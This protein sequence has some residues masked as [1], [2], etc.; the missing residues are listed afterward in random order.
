MTR[1]LRAP[2]RRAFRPLCDRLET[3]SL[4][5]SFPGTIVP[6]LPNLPDA[7]YSTVPASGDVNPYGVAYV[8]SNFPKVGATIHAGD[9][10]VSNFNASSNVQGTGTTIVDIH[11]DGTQSLF[12]TS[13]QPGL[14]TALGVLSRGFVVVGNVPSTLAPGSLQ[15]IDRAG[16]LVYTLTDS[17]LLD[18]PWDLT[19]VDHGATAQIFVSNVLSG[20][21]SRVNVAISSGANPITIQSITQLA[22]GYEHRT[23]PTA[24]VIGPTGL[25]Y[26][27]SSGTLYVASTGNNAIYG[28]P[29]AA[30]STGGNTKGTLVYKD[31][32]HL[33]GP[34]GLALAPNG[35]LLTTNGDAVHANPAEPSEL[36]EFTTAGTFVGELSLDPAQGAAFGLAVNQVGKAVTVATVNDDHNTLDL[37]TTTAGAV[38]FGQTNLVSDIPGVASFTDPNLKNPW[39]ISYGPG[40]PFWVSDNNLFNRSAGVSTLYNTIGQP[41]PPPPFGPLVVS[42]PGGLPTGQFF[43]PT[44]DFILPDG[45]K[46][47]FFFATLNGTIAGW[48]FAAGTTA[49][50]VASNSGAVYT[51]LTWANN[52]VANY[53]YAADA[54]GKIDVY[55]SSFH[56]VSGGGAFPFVDPNGTNGL[57]PY[58]IQALGGKLYVTYSGPPGS[59]GGI[60]DVFDTNGNFLRRIASNVAGGPLEEP[61]GLALAPASFGQFG[62]D[63]LVGN[64]LTGRISAFNPLTGNF[65]GEIVDP[66]GNQVSIPGLWGLIF[67]NGGLGGTRGTLYFVAGINGY[68]DGLLGALAPVLSPPPPG[69]P[70]PSSTV[71]IP[72]GSSQNGLPTS[73]L[74][75]IVPSNTTTTSPSPHKG[76]AIF[77]VHVFS[78][79]RP[80]DLV[81]EL[82]ARDRG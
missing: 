13:T 24:F 82:S 67:G 15:F 29:N 77:E 43:N 39:G 50:Q 81:P 42:I 57:T 64:V 69:T 78:P 41:F 25:A 8:P 68:A 62:G 70:T 2:Q 34:L 66:N 45:Q 79:N 5:S 9:I 58:N 14:S 60:V 59:P 23:D 33:E 36:I 19:I 53:I 6:N 80:R 76:P 17:A 55:D 75:T 3:R 31:N 52:G 47:V 72:T 51:G 61:W 28:I 1:S 27:P 56:L 20:T 4:L 40:G 44:S 18:G 63:L 54:T 37:R 30:T 12:F 7:S 46:G 74:S 35:D 71:T 21:V 65:K 49:Q 38:H 10:L 11:P 73:T 16:N 32:A 26:D 48:N 22:A